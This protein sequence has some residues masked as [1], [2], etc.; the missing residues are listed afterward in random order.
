M[1][2]VALLLVLS[3]AFAL[4]RAEDDVAALKAR[5]ATLEA[6]NRILRTRALGVPV[7]A[8]RLE[9]LPTLATP[10]EGKTTESP[11]SAR[12]DSLLVKDVLDDAG[13]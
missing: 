1:R 11:M 3:S 6:E 9:S 5:L 7:L 10:S 8:A 4:A 2:L 13:C 12:L